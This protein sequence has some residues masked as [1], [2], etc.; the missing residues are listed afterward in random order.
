MAM[1]PAAGYLADGVSMYVVF[2]S[3]EIDNDK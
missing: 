1:L 2:S 3:E